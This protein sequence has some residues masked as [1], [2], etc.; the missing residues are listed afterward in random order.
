MLKHRTLQHIP[1]VQTT[2]CIAESQDRESGKAHCHS[3]QSWHWTDS[4]WTSSDIWAILVDT[5]ALGWGL[6]VF[7]V[8]FDALVSTLVLIISYA[9]LTWFFLLFCHPPC[10]P[11]LH[12]ISPYCNNT[13]QLP[14]SNLYLSTLIATPPYLTHYQ[15]CRAHHD[16]L[17]IRGFGPVYAYTFFWV[18]LS[19]GWYEGGFQR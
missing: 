16:L 11:S 4:H 7:S 2:I 6:V 1:S 13:I 9:D 19:R 12:L 17:N 15:Y 3:H 5:I 8:W 14:N 18:T 10:P